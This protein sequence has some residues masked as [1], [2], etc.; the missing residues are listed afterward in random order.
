MSLVFIEDLENKDM[1]KSSCQTLTN[2]INCVSVMGKGIALEF[3]N[4]YPEMFKDYQKRC[5]AGEV[6]VGFPYVWRGLNKWVLNFPTKNFW[7]NPSKLE[8]IEDGI[9][10]FLMNYKGWG[11]KSLGLPK[12]GC[13]NGGLNW[14]DVRKIIVDKMSGIDILVEVYGTKL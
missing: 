4:R 12:L 6:K 14:V 7:Q 11:V 10:H 2:T 8:W 5:A 9:S 3:K 13:S 1:F